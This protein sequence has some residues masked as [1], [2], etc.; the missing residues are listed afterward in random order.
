MAGMSGPGGMP[1]D[2]QS[3]ARQRIM[4]GAVVAPGLVY[5]GS[6]DKQAELMKQAEERGVDVLFIFDV[7]VSP[8]NRLNKIV[9]NEARVRAVSMK[10]DSLARSSELLN[11]K[12]ERALL[13]ASGE[14]EVAKATEKFFAQF[15]E[16]VKV[17]DM[18][19]MKSEH[20]KPRLVQLLSNPKVSKLEKL[21]EVCLYHS[22]NL[23]DDEQKLTAC[24]IVMEGSEG[25]SLATGRPEDKQA[26]LDPLLPSYK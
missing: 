13:S 16:K 11:T 22:M 17:T 24:L 1:G 26:V 15:D 14:D 5:L 10:G 25:E 21:F 2:A 23:I 3:A 8:P 12:V 6:S 9:Q 18:P 4:P 7:T 19:A 20:V